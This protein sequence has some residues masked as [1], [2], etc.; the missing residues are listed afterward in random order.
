MGMEWLNY[1]H[2]LYFWTVARLGSIAAATRELNLTQPTIS[3]Q[4][5]QLEESLGEKLLEKEGRRLVLT[6][7]GR[8]AYRY[9]DEIFALGRELRDTLRDRPTGKAP[10]V[11]VGVADVIPKPIAHRVLRPAFRSAPELEMVCREAPSEV[12]LARL[13]EHEIDLV[14]TDAPAVGRAL[15]AF[16]HYLG[17][18]GTTFF[19]SA[20]LVR[21]YSAGFPSSMDGA[22]LLLPGAATQIRRTIEEWLDRTGLSPR[23]AGEFDDLALMTAFGRGGVGIFPGPTAIEGEIAKQ[24]EVGVVGRVP[25]LK[26]RFYAVTRERRMKN[27]LVTAI[28]AAAR[29]EVFPAE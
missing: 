8:I 15:R 3:V 14:L 19:G 9:A 2:L 11:T 18:S 1:H 6:E 25:E 16:N 21:E 27:P 24:S 28:T 29:R 23:R 10:R 22:P 13:S 5:R 20:A 26:Q 4:L 17:E 7:A 12:L